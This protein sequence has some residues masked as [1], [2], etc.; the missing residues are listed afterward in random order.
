[1][2]ITAAKDENS[3]G[4]HETWD[5]NLRGVCV[6]EVGQR[7][8]KGNRQIKGRIEVEGREEDGVEE[9]EENSSSK[10]ERSQ[11]GCDAS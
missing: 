4:G 8:V 1:M 6:E 5:I 7:R 10:G 11:I 2:N 9:K 3:G